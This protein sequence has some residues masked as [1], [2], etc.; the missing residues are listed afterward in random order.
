ML[1]IDR[2]RGRQPLAALM[3]VSISLKRPRGRK[4]LLSMPMTQPLRCPMDLLRAKR[5]ADSDEN[6]ERGGKY[7][8]HR[9]GDHASSVSANGFRCRRLAR[10][11]LLLAAS[12]RA[13]GCRQGRWSSYLWKFCAFPSLHCCKDDMFL[14]ASIAS[15][16]WK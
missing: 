5:D 13:G 6:A 15:I 11:R 16:C 3:L 2:P 7:V 9:I 12:S 1:V 14:C 4:V 8:I 10:H